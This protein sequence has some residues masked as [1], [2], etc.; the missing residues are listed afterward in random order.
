[1]LVVLYLR[2]FDYCF[3]KELH[4]ISCVLGCHENSDPIPVMSWNAN[5]AIHRFTLPFLSFS[6]FC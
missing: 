3:V 5:L 1:M 4:F 6:K 2:S